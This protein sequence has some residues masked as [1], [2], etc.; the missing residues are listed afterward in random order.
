MS[1]NFTVDEAHLAGFSVLA[2]ELSTQA[3][4]LMG[5][6][7]YEARPTQGFTGLMELLKPPVEQYAQATGVRLANRVDRLT[8]ISTELNRA[9]WMYSGA[10][11]SAYEKFDD[12]RLPGTATGYKDFPNP[13]SYPPGDE[14]KLKPPPHGEADIRALVDEVGGLINGVDDAIAALTT[15]SPVTELVEPMSGNWTELSRA[16]DVLTQVGDGAEL[17]AGNLTSQLGTLDAYWNGGAA[18]AFQ[19]YAGK[20]AQA[21]EMEGP[22]NRLVGQVYKAVAGEIEKVAQFMVSTLKTAVDKVAQ[23]AASSWIPGYG[24]YRIADAVRSAIDIIQEAYE[25]IRQLKN[26]ID[27]VQTVVDAAQN[28]VE[29]IEGKVEEQLAPIK[30]K[31]QQAEKGVNIAQDIAALK[32][33]DALTDLPENKDYSVGE[34]PRRPGG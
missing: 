17:V 31:V 29:F 20:I 9:A 26:V 25:L 12:P 19:D 23:A 10:D 27:T 4:S 3:A 13:A 6:I 2:D 32:D 22:I 14:P 24:W 18:I 28:P 33:A 11:K 7:N 21:L 8:S 1:E 30:E 34:N 15:W 5:H 16:G